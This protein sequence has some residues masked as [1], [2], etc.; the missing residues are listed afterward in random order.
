MK[1]LMSVNVEQS[2]HVVGTPGVVKLGRKET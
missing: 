2:P 1:S